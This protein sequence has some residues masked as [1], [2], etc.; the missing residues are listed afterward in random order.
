MQRNK[1]DRYS[2][3]PTALVV[4]GK[5]SGWKCRHQNKDA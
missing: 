3:T 1:K 2:I 5:S 4:D